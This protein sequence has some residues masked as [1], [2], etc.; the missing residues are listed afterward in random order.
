MTFDEDPPRL[1]ELAESDP[2]LR[3]ALRT[4]R[5]ELP[6]PEQLT[7]IADGTLGALS[8]GALPAVG[9]AKLGVLKLVAVVV[10][11]G[12]L[13]AVGWVWLGAT[14]PAGSPPQPAVPGE[15]TV[16]NPESAP[17]PRV[18]QG[19]S[20]DT[21][22]THGSQIEVPESTARTVGPPG[23]NVVLDASAPAAPRANQTVSRQKPRVPAKVAPAVPR[24]APE[25]PGQRRETDAAS[26][27]SE[28]ALI[29]AAQHALSRD[30]QRTLSLLE[31]HLALYPKGQFAEERDMLQLDALAR[32]KMPGALRDRAREFLEK[33]PGSVHGPRVRRLL[34]WRWAAGALVLG[35]APLGRSGRVV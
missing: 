2:A 4:V 9:A 16:V 29:S 17:A 23:Q 15:A 26:D 6:S 1:S 3:D 35:C 31:R 27:E 19:S 7:R 18:A 10:G 22:V 21:Q 33:Y 25:T 24:S 30:A 14:P 12:M 28:V 34:G 13:G 20:A 32:L 11:V 5:A 8:G